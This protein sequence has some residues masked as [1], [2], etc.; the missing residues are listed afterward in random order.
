MLALSLAVLLTGATLP[1]GKLAAQVVPGV[2]VQAPGGWAPPALGVRFGYD[3]QQ[4]NEVLGAQL[5]L[6]IL[7]GGQIELM[8]SVDVTFLQG[9]KEYQY[10]FEGVYVLDGRAGGFYAG[11]GIGLRNTIFTSSQG[12]ETELGYSAVIG[13]R[14]VGLGLVVPQLEYRWVFIDEAPITYKQFTFGL[15]V[16]LWQPTPSR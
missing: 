11:A 13:I 12:R 10:N 14:L 2:Q 6:P 16:A 1:A 3:N 8:P 4:Q 5:R 9:L 15:S 7:R